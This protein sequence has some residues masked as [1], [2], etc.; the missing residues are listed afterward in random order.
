MLESLLDRVGIDT[1]ASADLG[2]GLTLCSPPQNLVVDFFY[3]FAPSLILLEH[4]RRQK[5]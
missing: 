2:V 4:L 1:K 5:H 3:Y